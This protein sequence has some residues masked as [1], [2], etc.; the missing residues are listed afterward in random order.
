[1][2]TVTRDENKTTTTSASSRKLAIKE[3]PMTMEYTG[4]DSENGDSTDSSPSPRIRSPRPKIPVVS[5]PVSP[6][7]SRRRN[8]SE[9]NKVSWVGIVTQTTTITNTVHTEGK[10]GTVLDNNDVSPVPRVLQI[11]EQ[12]S[13]N[14]VGTTDDKPEGNTDDKSEANTDE[15]DGTY[16]CS[17]CGNRVPFGPQCFPCIQPTTSQTAKNRQILRK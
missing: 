10:Q 5:G 7:L 8:S 1:M 2:S 15:D 14:I 3:N 4:T 13:D 9:D 17:I 12:R 16:V 11:K 6:R